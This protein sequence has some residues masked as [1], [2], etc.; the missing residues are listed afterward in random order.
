M[1]VC[2]IFNIAPSYRKA[3]YKLM[4]AELDVDFY[5][6]DYSIEGIALL[7]LNNELSNVYSGKKL[8]WQKGAIRRAFAKKYDAY[9][10]TGNAGIRSNWIITLLARLMG[11]KVYLWSHGLKGNESK[12]DF[13]KNIC[14]LRLAGNALLY[15][16]RAQERLALHGFTHTTVIYNSLDYDSQLAIRSQADNGAFLH[17]HFKNDLPM[18]CYL[19]RVNAA[20]KID[21][22]L[23]A[24]KDIECN[25]IIV[26]SGPEE[27]KLHDKTVEFGLTNKVWFYG[28]C[29]DE[30]LIG[31]ILKNSTVTV[32]P[33]SI[34]LTAIHSLMFGT[35]VITHDDHISQAPEAEVIIEGVSG[36]YYQNG[37]VESLRQTIIK[38]LN[39]P[40][41]SEA[42]YK[43]IEKKYNPHTQIEILKK[44]FGT[45][46]S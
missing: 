38:A 43:I 25:L 39:S 29:Y 18:I 22:L 31:T 21:M 34:G 17:E 23:E 4:Q 36:Y 6:G 32:N 24:I 2:C 42:C 15:G 45:R 3:I 5:C 46:K 37:S 44:I 8:I 16:E 26:G 13:Y 12:S 11:R 19:G 1:K 40:K 7:P 33:S 20:K 35:P 27:E 10:L 28:E 9:I 14:Y 30:V 41:D